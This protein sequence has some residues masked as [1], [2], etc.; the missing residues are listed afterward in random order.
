V[1]GNA[2]FLERLR[3]ARERTDRL[4]SMVRP[5]A[6]Y[7]RP[8]AERHR[9]IFYVGHLEA[10]DWN[11]VCRRDLGLPSFHPEFDRLF[12]FGID[13]GPDA[14]P[15]DRPSDWPAL[16][17]IDRYG[18]R[19]R[20]EVDKVLERTDDLW[21]FHV[22]LEHRLMHAE[23]LTYLLHRLPAASKVRKVAAIDDHPEPQPHRV[24]I[25]EGY[26]TLGR[27]R[28]GFQSNAFG[29]D[30]EFSA[31]V[32]RTPAFSI[33]RFN[34]TNG[35]FLEF[36][37]AGGYE[38]RAYWTAEAWDWIQ[39]NGVRHPNFWREDYGAWTYETMFGA[40]P[41]PLSWPVYVS[42]A[43]AAAYARWTGRALPTEA[44]YH[45]AAFGS[46]T[47]LEREFPWGDMPPVP[48]V[49]GNFDAVRWNPE[50]VGTY[51]EGD[52]AFGVA[53]LMSNGWEWTSSV[54]G[55][56]RGFTPFRLYP[57]YSAT[58]FDGAHYVL[59][60]ASPRTPA[61]LLR[62]TFRNWFQPHYQNVYA[63]FRC[64]DN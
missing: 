19:A 6:L 8:I 13:P 32:T 11:I 26:V 48:E 34:V 22:A 44:Q 31:E 30:N 27:F 3:D 64:V 2:E 16:M 51:R 36:I 10:F 47:E 20:D 29:W 23:T 58:F 35:R 24:D 40:V 43:E 12:E 17:Q 7:E 56:L 42:H 14:L 21:P 15:G 57:E 63:T 5:E 28:Q 60:G 25:P 38:E 1:K 4:F 53:D 59:K 52:S 55:P 61:P 62:R 37:K 45:R 18:V 41:L 49:H 33:D 39:R 9:L 46:P 50:P 54:F